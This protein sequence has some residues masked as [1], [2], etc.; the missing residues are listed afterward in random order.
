MPDEEDPKADTEIETPPPAPPTEVVPLTPPKGQRRRR[1]AWLPAFVFSIP[2]I[3]LFVFGA[4]LTGA[5]LLLPAI[6]VAAR[7]WKWSA[8]AALV[9][10]AGLGVTRMPV[11]EY[12]RRATE[13]ETKRRASGPAAFTARDLAGIWGFNVVMGIGG[14]ACGLPEVAQETLLLAAPGGKP[15]RFEGDFAMRSPKVRAALREMLAEAKA[16]DRERIEKL[17][18]KEVV[19]S[20][21]D[22]SD[23]PRVG[24]ALNSLTLTASGRKLGREWSL[25]VSGRVPISYPSEG[26]L[27]IAGVPIYEGLF[28]VAQERRWL[29]P[30]EADWRWT[31]NESDPRLANTLP[32]VS[33]LEKRLFPR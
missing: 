5:A 9:V 16:S 15:K 3:W 20:R 12:S 11:K 29:H 8:I 14:L 18:P 1:I 10:I 4:N 28:W 13:L 23:S 7:R 25:D 21:Y 19:W 24:L 2:S 30:Y 27:S 33:W 31:V 6:L 32:K 22:V 17:G 26:T